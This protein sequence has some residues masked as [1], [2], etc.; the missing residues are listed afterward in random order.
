[1]FHLDFRPSSLRTLFRSDFLV[2]I[3]LFLLIDSIFRAGFDWNKS[4]SNRL[5]FDI[6][7][8]SHIWWATKDFLEQP[9]ASDIVLLGASDMESAVGNT[10]ATYLN[11][12]D[13]KLLHHRCSY[14]ESK[15]QQL[16]SPYKDVFSLAIGGAMPSDMYFT[17]R[18]LLSG[19]HRPKVIVCSVVPRSLGDAQFGDPKSSDAY[20]I[21]SKLGGTQDFEVPWLCNYWERAD[22]KLQQ[23]VSIYRHKFELASWQHHMLIPILSTLLHEDF[24][25]VHAPKFDKPAAFTLLP[26]DT[27]PSRFISYPFDPMHPA[28]TNNTDTFEAHFTKI[29]QRVFKEQFD[30]LKRLGDFCRSQGISLVLANSPMAPEVRPFINLESYKLYLAQVSSVASEYGA[31]FI[32]LN[33]PELFNHDDFADAIHLNGRGGE[34]YFDQIAVALSRQSK[35]AAADGR[36]WQIQR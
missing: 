35:L 2:G 12:P 6:P 34:K 24:S 11:A 5:T 21:M 17:T 22:Y 15:L 19:E 7:Y 13:H 16:D 23:I 14:L 28:F 32:D 18:T 25:V 1:M 20:R 4:D 33:R 10:E 8:R 30:C 26:T 27:S 9:K 31:T 36:H 3:L 29:D